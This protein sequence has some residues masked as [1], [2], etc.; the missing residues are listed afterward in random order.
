MKME[1]TTTENHAN[2]N[3]SDTTVAEQQVD[4]QLKLF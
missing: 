3:H 4:M 1:I 2:H